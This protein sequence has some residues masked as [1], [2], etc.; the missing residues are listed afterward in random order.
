MAAAVGL[1]NILALLRCPAGQGRKLDF[2]QVDFDQV[3]FDQVDFGRALFSASV[4]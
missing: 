1:G 4:S 3:D 2:D